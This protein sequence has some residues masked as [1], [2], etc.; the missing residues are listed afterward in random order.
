MRSI[1]GEILLVLVV[2]ALVA[3]WRFTPPP[4]ALA[5]QARLPANTH[6]H[7]EKVMADVTVTPGR[8]GPVDIALYLAA[9]DFTALVPQ[10]VSINLSQPQRGIEPI[11]FT[12]TLGEDGFW[13]VDNANIPVGGTW[14]LDIEV[15]VSMF[16]LARLKGEIVIP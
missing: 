15:R 10:G 14:S 9:G 12:A 13:H 1:R 7:T 4:R 6:I 16:E 11:A 5:E 2:L 8:P 3:G